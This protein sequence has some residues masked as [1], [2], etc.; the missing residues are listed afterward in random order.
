MHKKFE[1]TMLD[2]LLGVL[3]VQL[4]PQELWDILKYTEPRPFEL[5]PSKLGQQ[6]WVPGI[7]QLFK[8]IQA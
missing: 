3:L 4:C 2:V 5:N 8:P 1:I 7:I 6:E